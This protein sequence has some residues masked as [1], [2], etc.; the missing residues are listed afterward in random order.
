MAIL[1]ADN[2][3]KRVFHTWSSAQGPQRRADLQKLGLD[4]VQSQE[5][6][7]NWVLCKS[8]ANM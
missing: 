3:E 8:L 1:A 6:L 5:R 4:D 2:S 7:E